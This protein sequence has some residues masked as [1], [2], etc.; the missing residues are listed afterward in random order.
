MRFSNSVFRDATDFFPLFLRTLSYNKGYDLILVTDID[1][2]ANYDCPVNLK[3]VPMKFSELQ[4]RV[5][6]LFGEKS[7][8]PVPYKIN[9]YRPMFGVLFAELLA[10][11]D[12]WGHCD[13]DVLLGD[14]DD[15]LSPVL[16]KDFDKIFAVG[17]MTLVKNTPENNQRYSRSVRGEDPWYLEMIQTSKSMNFD[18]DYHEKNIHTIFK[19]TGADI[20]AEDFAMNVFWGSERFVRAKYNPQ[21]ADFTGRGTVPCPVL[22]KITVAIKPNKGIDS[23]ELIAMSDHCPTVSFTQIIGKEE[24][25]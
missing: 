12:Y 13:C 22:G 11:Y 18:E 20:F 4:E 23:F 3:V 21:T 6:Q 25:K 14:L 8:L 5:K 2:E 24:S 16:E 10:G 9:D 7:V 19:E 1:V 15:F 17:H